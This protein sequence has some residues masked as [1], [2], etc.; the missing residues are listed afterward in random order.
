VMLEEIYNFLPLSD[1]LLTSGMPTAEQLADASRSGVQVVI[2]LAMPDSER[3]L[4]DE[5]SI[6]EGLG[7]QYVGIPVLW[8]GPTQRNLE[9]FMDAMDAHTD[10]RLLVHCQANYRATGF[11]TLYRV[12]RLGWD[13]EEAFK[14][15]RRIWNPDEYPVWKKFI[16]ENLPGP[17]GNPTSEQL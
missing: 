8:E 5:A 16:E 7:M 13:P 12:L 1:S 2:N 3:A 11:V 15:L 6:V 4:P 14:D 9:D 10:S 17:S